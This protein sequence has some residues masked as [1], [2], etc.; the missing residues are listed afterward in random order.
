MQNQQFNGI[1]SS[2]VTPQINYQ[3]ILGQLL[4]ALAVNA[5]KEQLVKQLGNNEQIQQLPRPE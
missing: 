3:N 2:A 4:T 5:Q 1:S